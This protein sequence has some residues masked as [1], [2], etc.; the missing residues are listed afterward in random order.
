[1]AKQIFINLAVKDLQKSMDFYTAIGFTNNPQ[2]SDESGK[3][4]VWCENIF[5]MILTH[6]KFAG[7]AT[8]PIADTK[9]NIAGLFSLLLESLDEV[10]NL[11]ANGLKAGGIEPSEI[12]DYG[13]MQQR[14]LEDFDGHTWEIFY[15]DISKFPN[16]EPQA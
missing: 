9:A 3:C 14:T 5:L 16:Q 13:F 2:F 7:F 15:M 1:M 10:N 4:M 12:K 6:E 11:M 8:K